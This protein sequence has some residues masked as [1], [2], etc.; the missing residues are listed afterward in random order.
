MIPIQPRA[1]KAPRIRLLLRNLIEVIMHIYKYLHTIVACFEFLKTRNENPD[2]IPVSV[3]FSTCFCSIMAASLK[4][5]NSS[6]VL[7]NL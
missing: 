4:F 2:L 6:P 5:L 3:S 1:S 7:L